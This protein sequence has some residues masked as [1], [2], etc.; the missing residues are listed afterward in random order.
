[1]TI[2]YEVYAA[3]QPSTAEVIA[4]PSQE[5]AGHGAVAVSAPFQASLRKVIGR[6]GVT[7]G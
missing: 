1:M 3:P 2:G 4:A 6:Q 5:G 7:H